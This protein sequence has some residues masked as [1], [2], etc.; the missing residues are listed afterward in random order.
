MYSALL[1][2][3]RKASDMGDLLSGYTLT[4]SAFTPLA[5]RNDTILRPTRSLP[6]SLMN[7]ASTPERPSDITPLNTEPP[8]TAPMGWSFLKIMSST[9]SPIPTTLR[10]LNPF[11]AAN[12]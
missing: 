4:L 12:I 5:L 8:G 9:V 6:A 7:V 11:Q 1:S 3:P 10:I 2:S